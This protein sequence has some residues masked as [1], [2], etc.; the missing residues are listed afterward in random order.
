MSCPAMGG[1]VSTAK[2]TMVKIIPILVPLI[3]TFVVRLLRAAGKRLWI[4]PPTKPYTIAHTYNPPWEL[5]AIQQKV[6]MA[7]MST[8]GIIELKTPKYRSA[9]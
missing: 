5:T 2:L 7:V 6:V 1:P 3:F 9:R 8:I 4:P